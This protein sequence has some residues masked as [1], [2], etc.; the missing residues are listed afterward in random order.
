MCGG[1]CKIE[2]RSSLE[3][4][5]KYDIKKNILYEM[6]Y[7]MF[8]ALCEAM[9]QCYVLFGSSVSLQC[10]KDKASELSYSVCNACTNHVS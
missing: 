5:Y 7:R 6:N 8:F 2:I 9:I 3:L 10:R 4:G 1:T